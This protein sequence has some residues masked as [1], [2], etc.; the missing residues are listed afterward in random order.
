MSDPAPAPTVVDLGTFEGAPVTRAGVEIPSAAGGLR[1]AM[2]VEPRILHQGDEGYLVIKYVVQKVRFDPLKKDE[3][4]GDQERVHVLQAESATFIADE[5]V[6]KRMAEHE[7]K[8][9]RH[10]EAE[11]GT[12]RLPDDKE[13]EALLAEHE[14]GE[15]ADGLRGGCPRCDEEAAAEASEQ[16]TEPTPIGR[17]RK[18]TT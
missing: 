5:L 11:K 6:E 4:D 18:A 10:R 3:P 8:V 9:A 1:E 16:V 2:K 14:H 13:V 12:Q 15:H 7:E 17:A